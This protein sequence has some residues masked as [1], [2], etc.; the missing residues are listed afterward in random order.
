[1]I[2]EAE[3]LRYVLWQPSRMGIRH[4]TPTPSVWTQM[5][6]IA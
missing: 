6:P 3:N 1:L 2:V 4:I 5:L